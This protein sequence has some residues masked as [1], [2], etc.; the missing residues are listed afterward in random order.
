MQFQPM[1]GSRCVECL[2]EAP[3]PGSQR[4]L[5]LLVG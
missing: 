4:A 3:N 5:A 2:E 1:L